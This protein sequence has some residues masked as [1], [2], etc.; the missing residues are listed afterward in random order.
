LGYQ[1]IDDLDDIQNDAVK[2]GM[3]A[4]LNICLVL[5]AAGYA[6]DCYAAARDICSQHL[7]R[8]EA[9]ARQLPRGVGDCILDLK[10]RLAERI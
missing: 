5:Q 6:G 4:S 9:L 7:A 1:I 3:P 10:Q 8:V 2:N